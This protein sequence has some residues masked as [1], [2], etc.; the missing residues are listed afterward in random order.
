M[1]ASGFAPQLWFKRCIA[2][3]CR[4]ARERLATA[5]EQIDFRALRELAS[6]ASPGGP[7]EHEPLDAYYARHFLAR[8]RR[9]AQGRILEI[10]SDDRFV[11]GARAEGANRTSLRFSGERELLR[12]MAALPSAAYDTVILGQVLPFVYEPDEILAQVNRILLAGGV[13]LATA[14]GTCC[15]ARGG[16]ERPSYWGFTVCCARQLLERHFPGA[17]INIESFGNVLVAMADAFGAGAGELTKRELDHRDPH[18]PFLLGLRVR[19]RRQDSLPEA[20]GVSG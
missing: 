8:E 13:L 17:G 12:A 7:C 6:H 1:K 4:T 16:R 18:Y 15:A 9:P 14:S 3:T 2:R 5:P 19:T 10:M 20:R 11:R